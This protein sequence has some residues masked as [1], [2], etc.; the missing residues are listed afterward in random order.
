MSKQEYQS[1]L[2][3]AEEM[4]ERVPADVLI[5][6]SRN[7][8]VLSQQELLAVIQRL[9]DRRQDI[10]ELLSIAKSLDVLARK[11]QKLSDRLVADVP[12]ALGNPEEAGRRRT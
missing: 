2:R 7:G 3:Q 9:S 1:L 11:M 10:D 4:R 8:F 6:M 12:D 5:A